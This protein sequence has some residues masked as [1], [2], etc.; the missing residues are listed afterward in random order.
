MC[1]FRFKNSIWLL[2]KEG[3]RRSQ[4]SPPVP[5][6]NHFEYTPHPCANM[7]SVTK[8][9]VHSISHYRQTTI[10]ARS[11]ATWA[12]NLGKFRRACGF[13][14]W[15]LT[16]RQ[17]DRKKHALRNTPHRYFERSSK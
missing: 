6:V 4:T 9:E 12:E 5:V 3:H 14:M 15:E 10:E 16:D 8:P 2:Y 7:T 11:L 17:T 13:E 1:P